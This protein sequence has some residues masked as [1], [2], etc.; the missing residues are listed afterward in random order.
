MQ[1]SRH[2]DH[3]RLHRGTAVT[4]AVLVIPALLLIVGMAPWV[5]HMFL[6]VLVT[7]TEAHRDTFDKTTTVVLMPEAM[8]SNYVNRAM[9]SQFG[10]LTASTRQHAL[11]HAPPDIP[12]S[13]DGVLMRGTFREEM[14]RYSRNGPDKLEIELGPFSLSLFPEGFPHSSVE[15]WEY[16]QRPKTFADQEEL[17]F[18]A[19]GTVIRSPWTK[20]GWPW[21]ATQD[22]LYEPK[23]IQDWQESQ[24]QVKDKMRER[25][26]LAE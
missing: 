9:S 22:L 7:R 1:R 18:M 25:Y 26:K 23:Q 17:H 5:A 13:L 21:V 10:D 6:D 19:Y 2:T 20:L 12:S 24:L 16:I 3:H 4:E 8:M 14:F 15:G 11:A